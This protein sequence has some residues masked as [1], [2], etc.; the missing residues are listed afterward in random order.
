[1]SLRFAGLGVIAVAAAAAVAG[2]NPHCLAGP[3]SEVDPRIVPLWLDHVEEA[4]SFGQLAV[5]APWLLIG[6][7][8][9]PFLALMPTSWAFVT[10]AR[11]ERAGWGLALLLLMTALAVALWEARGS[12]FA[13][14]LVV[15]GMAYA[16]TEVRRKLSPRGP[17]VLLLGL[18]LAYTVP[19]QAAETIAADLL[20]HRFGL[21]SGPGAAAAAGMGSASPYRTCAA[22]DSFAG[23]AVR[24]VGLVLVESNLGPSVLLDT[25]HATLAAP[26]HRNS[27]GLIDGL[28]AL[29]AAPAEAYAI[30]ARRHV[31]YVAICPGD[32]EVALIDQIAP[33][34]LLAGLLTGRVPNWL[35]PIETSGPLKLWRVVAPSTAGKLDAV[36]TGTVSR[37]RPSPAIP[38][39]P[40]EPTVPAPLNLRGSLPPSSRP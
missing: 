13:S 24:P 2:I 31:T 15:P 3:Y 39:I 21:Y 12:T 37:S 25:P 6:L 40:V 5:G 23:L 34:G 35:Q 18:V 17:I 16:V 29:E 11:S 1:M 33:D 14:V 36:P 28:T 9:A 4:H 10:V 22:R 8:L 32:P 30:I 27:G 38:P 26:Y 7:Y 19:N 20:R